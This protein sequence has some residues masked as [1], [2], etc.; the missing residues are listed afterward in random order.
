MGG[1]L[2]EKTVQSSEG[3][4]A[5]NVCNGLLFLI[6]CCG[7][8]I[9]SSP[10]WNHKS[11]VFDIYDCTDT[12]NLRTNSCLSRGG[13]GGKSG[14]MSHLILSSLWPASDSIFQIAHSFWSRGPREPVKCQLGQKVS[15]QP[16]FSSLDVASR[17]FKHGN[18]LPTSRDRVPPSCVSVFYY[19]SGKMNTLSSTESRFL[20]ENE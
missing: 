20:P 13:G 11:N 6:G 12:T 15:L 19:S 18:T 9:R 3:A 16:N 8:S 17:L 4:C 14:S 10:T 2:T 1:F 5:V 7:A